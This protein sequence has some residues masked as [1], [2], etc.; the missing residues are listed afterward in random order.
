MTP[1]P[2]HEKLSR[3]LGEQLSGADFDD[4]ERHVQI[5][6]RCQETLDRLSGAEPLTLGRPDWT[7]SVHDPSPEFVRRLRE[8]SP[9]RLDC[10]DSM[11]EA[12]CEDTVSG[13]DGSRP[14]VAGYDILAELGR[15]GMGVVYQARHVRLGRVVA[16]KMLLAGAHASPQEVARFRVEAEAVAQLQH[17]NIVQIFEVG[18]EKGCPY[19]ALEYVAG[20][21][22]SQKLRGMPLPDG[23]AARLVEALARAVHAAH[24][25]GIVH[26]D[27]KPA[28]VLLA[29]DGTPKITDF[30]LAKRLNAATAP[31]QSGALLGTPDYMAP[32]QAEGRST[33]PATDVYG[34]GAILYRLLTGRPPFL[35]ATPLDT[36]VRVRTEE[37]VRPA[38]LHPRVARDLETIC[39]KCLQ[40]E[41]RKRYVSAEA[42][43]E[44][45]GRFQSGESIQA[46]PVSLGERAVKW[47]KRRPALATL[48]AVSTAA[49]VALVASLAGLWRNAE[50]RAQAVQQLDEAQNLLTDRKDELARLARAVREQEKEVKRK[51]DEAARERARTRQARV[52]TRRALYIRDMHLAQAALEKEHINHLVM[53]LEKHRP[54]PGEKDVRGFE[55]HYLWRLCHGA[56]LALRGHTGYIQDIR[57]SPDGKILTSLSQEEGTVK[58]WDAVTGAERPAPWGRLTDVAGMAYSRDGK[59]LATGYR[60]GTVRFWDV[61]SGRARFSIRAHA[62]AVQ[63]LAFALGGQALATGSRDGTVALWDLATLRMQAVLPRGSGPVRR[64]ELSADGRSLAI[65]ETYAAR[66]WDVATRR[67]RFT[68]QAAR[69][70][71]LPG[72]AFSP[73][74]NLVAT[75]EGY[76]FGPDRSGF[77]RLWDTATGK[78]LPPALEVPHRGAWALTF[79]P[80]GKTLAVGCDNGAV[81][82]WDIATRRV[83]HAFYG[84]RS[85]VHSVAFSPDGKTLA[86]GGNDKVVLLWDAVTAD[87]PVPLQ[88]A[89]GKWTHAAIAPDGNTMALLSNTGTLKL[90][91]R[92]TGQERV[93][94]TQSGAEVSWALAF[95]PDGKTLATGSFD[96]T[97]KLW[98]VTTGRERITLRGHAGRLQCIGYAPDGKTLASGSVK[99][100]EIRLWDAVTGKP[101]F[102]LRE[103]HAGWYA[104][105]LAFG[106]DRNT[107]FSG[108]SWG[109]IQLWD[110]STRTVRFTLKATEGAGWDVTSLAFS[111]DGKLLAAGN[112]DGTVALWDLA[113]LRK[114]LPLVA[115]STVA[116]GAAPAG[117]GLL[118]HALLPLGPAEKE[119]VTFNGFQGAVFPVRFTP[120]GTTVVSGHLNGAVKFWDVA[121]LQERFTLRCPAHVPYSLAFTPDGKVLVCGGGNGEVYLWDA[122]K[123]SGRDWAFVP[124]PR[125]LE[126]ELARHRREAGEAE[127]AGL[128]FAAAWHLDRL[129]RLEPDSAPLL[130]RRARALVELGQAERALADLSVLFRQP[131][132]EG[133][134]WF[135]RG[136]AHAQHGDWRK[137]LADYSEVLKRTPR[138]G[139][140]W[141]SR[142]VAHARLGET[143]KAEDA[144]RRAVKYAGVIRLRSDTSSFLRDQRPVRS[145]AGHWPAVAADLAKLPAQGKAN[146]WLWRARG[147]AGAAQGQWPQAAIDLTRAAED[148]PDDFETWYVLARAYVQLGRW[149]DAARASARAVKLGRQ[150]GSAWYLQGIVEQNRRAFDKAADSFSQAIERGADGWGAWANRGIARAEMG[151]YSKASQDLAKASRLPNALFTVSYH[152]ALVRLQVADREGYRK[153]CAELAKGLERAGNPAVATW[154]ADVCMLTPDS[155]VNLVPVVRW[156]ERGAAQPTNRYIYLHRLGQALYRTGRWEAAVLELNKALLLRA[157][158]AWAVEDWLFLAMAHHRLG[159]GAEA[160]RWLDRATDWIN[161]EVRERS[162]WAVPLHWTVRLKLLTLEREAENLLQ[163]PKQ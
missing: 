163:K 48:A 137:A 61:R 160:R 64:M 28:N 57:F 101:K 15:G 152:L 66:V 125:S 126:Q 20:E 51:L 30:G 118:W 134:L 162:Q 36:L 42:L 54:P 70:A 147:L 144:Y 41:P 157:S 135:T 45:L 161:R 50:A 110:L 80:D 94:R 105:C 153:A 5:C 87:P 112:Y 23:D 56:R 117:K 102:R 85:R 78:E 60:N 131:P 1:C 88:E 76:A 49:A 13:N 120:D 32:E 9:S 148:N 65:S 145:D 98:D 96:S 90:R 14:V 17:P 119:I 150:E 103:P 99:P 121:M 73:D 132:Q 6:A 158:E 136:R 52:D 154:V 86:S 139:A 138:D 84:N 107:L 44:D 129:L 33:G 7:R 100:S 140:V 63:G 115:A 108:S 31:T 24:Q 27:L 43:A 79:A 11:S 10:A 19:L 62:G 21:S 141:L 67:V 46:R 12:V 159:H 74:G 25:R 38:V 128:W 143:D 47:M 71:E 40:K 53:L 111:P 113:R 95:A 55:W 39:L 104:S 123:A 37:P 156:L 3:F 116:L 82:L 124:D 34:L 122:R 114:R 68:V 127:K 155:G 26:R 58:L 83:R 130:A 81:K 89:T 4:V 35:A 2:S 16:L 91:D 8:I 22:L 151:Q 93:L 72:L 146:G 106:P 149:A 142:S 97:V 77:V 133:E 109:A 18:E 92:T 59:T 75:G 29:A 69:G